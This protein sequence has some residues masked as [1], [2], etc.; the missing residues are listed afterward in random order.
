MNSWFVLVG[1][2]V[3]LLPHTILTSV[4]SPSFRFV[5][6]PKKINPDIV[7]LFLTSKMSLAS[8][9]TCNTVIKILDIMQ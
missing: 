1:L 6:Y 8:N 5:I 3:G 9:Q 2:G 4:V 7:I